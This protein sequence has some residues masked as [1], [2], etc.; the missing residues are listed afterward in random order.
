M[1]V[2]MKVPVTSYSIRTREGLRY[3]RIWADRTYLYG[4]DSDLSFYRL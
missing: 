3:F 4:V 1:E 2:Q